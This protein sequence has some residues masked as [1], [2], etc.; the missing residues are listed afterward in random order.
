MRLTLFSSKTPQETPKHPNSTPSKPNC[1]GVPRFGAFKSIKS[2][3]KANTTAKERKTSKENLTTRNTTTVW[4]KRRPRKHPKRPQ[5]T[6]R[7]P[8][9]GKTVEVF[10]V[11][12]PR[13]PKITPRAFQQQKE[14]LTTR[15]TTTV[16]PK[17]KPRRHPKRP[18]SNP[19]APLPSQTVVVFRV[20]QLSKV[21][22]KSSELPGFKSSKPLS[23]RASKPPN[24]RASKPPRGPAAEA[25]P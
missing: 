18:R 16:W 3:S 22:R 5:S 23:L 1:S 21:L 17:R 25:E 4:P 9:T 2:N 7:T 10:R 6:P 20:F 24:L 15:N 13:G 11:L 8:L 14:N 12:K 19:R